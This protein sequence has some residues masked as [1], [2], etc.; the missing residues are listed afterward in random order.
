MI[1]EVYSAQMEDL[2]SHGYVVASIT[3]PYDAVL[4]RCRTEPTS[5]MTAS[6]GR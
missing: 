2:A 1:S 6:A 4:T 5:P 3:H